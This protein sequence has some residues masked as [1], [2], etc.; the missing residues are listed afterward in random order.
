MVDE[1]FEERNA[2]SPVSQSVFTEATPERNP[3]EEPRK[4]SVT[5]ALELLDKLPLATDSDSTE[6][7]RKLRDA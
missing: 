4:L 2:L 6:I 5:E 1:Q 7:I 3:V